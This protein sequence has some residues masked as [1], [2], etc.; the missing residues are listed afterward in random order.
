MEYLGHVITAQRLKPNPGHI[1][2]VKQYKVPHDLYTVRHFLGL[3][4]FYRRFVPGFA[5]IASPVHELTKKGVS[6]K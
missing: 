6:F 4:S 1:E 5:R 3:T 2:A